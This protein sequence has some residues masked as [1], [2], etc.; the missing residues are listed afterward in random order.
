MLIKC[1]QKQS[2]FE[3]LN[4]YIWLPVCLFPGIKQTPA[5]H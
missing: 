2:D 1:E 3:E 5:M 4:A